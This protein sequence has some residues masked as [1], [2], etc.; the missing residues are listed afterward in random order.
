MWVTRRNS[1]APMRKVALFGIL[2]VFVWVGELVS[3]K[4]WM[5]EHV[6]GC[7]RWR[8][9]YFSIIYL[10][11]RVST[12]TCRHFW[13]TVSFK[14]VSCCLFGLGDNDDHNWFSAT[15]R[16][17]FLQILCKL[18]YKIGVL[19]SSWL[20]CGICIWQSENETKKIIPRSS[21]LI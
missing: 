10:C 3:V 4:A 5:R 17:S 9:A 15:Y 8:T 11:E 20:T 13:S 2:C 21:E 12:C 19:S 7:V 1:H 18:W 6:R 14:P 16:V